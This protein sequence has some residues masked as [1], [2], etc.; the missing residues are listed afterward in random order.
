MFRVR[1]AGPEIDPVE[2]VA[3]LV[4]EGS[5][6][7]PPGGDAGK[8]RPSGSRWSD[9]P[10]LVA[11]ERQL[12]PDAHGAPGLWQR[13]LREGA[14]SDVWTGDTVETWSPLGRVSYSSF[15]ALSAFTQTVLAS[16]ELRSAPSGGAA[17]SFLV[18]SSVQMLRMD[19]DSGSIGAVTFSPFAFIVP[20]DAGVEEAQ[21][22]LRDDPVVFADLEV[23]HDELRALGIDERVEHVLVW[24]L[25]RG[26]NSS[27]VDGVTTERNRRYPIGLDLIEGAA[28]LVGRLAMTVN[29][30]MRRPERDPWFRGRVERANLD[31]LGLERRTAEECPEVGDVAPGSV[32]SDA[33]IAIH[34]TMASAI[35]LARSLAVDLDGRGPIL[36]FEHDT[37]NS[38]TA[39][40][41]ALSTAVQ[42]AE[43]KR[44]LFVAHSRGGLVG[45]Q[46]IGYLRDDAP[47]V[48]AR[49]IAVGTPFA[50]TPLIGAAES[51]L[52]GMHAALGALRLLTGPALDA[53][54]RL[55]GLLVKGRLPEGIRDMHEEA[56]YLDAFAGS[57]TADITAIAGATDPN[58]PAESYGVA[59]VVKLG[60]IRGIF[61]DAATK[62][63]R[64]NDYVVPTAS[65]LHRIPADHALEVECD[66]FTYFSHPEVRA[67]LAADPWRAVRAAG[68][69]RL[70]W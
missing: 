41:K 69:E 7:E 9:L 59:G 55:A 47:D 26:S 64:R 45:R 24:R 50:G 57:S 63:T 53:V 3:Q 23:R 17:L 61:R 33:I 56:S 46:A 43:L 4:W 52:L 70:R 68:E 28:Y 30:T 49:L 16:L 15:G 44:V 40:A 19:D 29:R 58:G 21:L 10:S 54:S 51:G 66:H 18:R 20:I 5:L 48:E 32:G 25:Y 2:R 34:G 42:S 1:M 62:E 35:P 65:A 13:L 11:M 27:V 14:A 37:W 36:R 60:G 67:R 31:D 39:N 22:E 38:I 6:G 8:V 12:W